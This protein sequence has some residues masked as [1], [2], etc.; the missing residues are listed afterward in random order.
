MPEISIAVPKCLMSMP[1][2]CLEGV[3]KWVYNATIGRCELRDNRLCVLMPGGFNTE[4]ECEE[5]CYGG[6]LNAFNSCI[7]VQVL[8]MECSLVTVKSLSKIHRIG[9]YS[10]QKDEAYEV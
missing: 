7:T 9:N 8:W 3:S 6:E 1:Q 2:S 4:Q 10:L 5:T